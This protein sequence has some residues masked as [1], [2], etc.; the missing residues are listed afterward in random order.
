MKDENHIIHYIYE[1]SG[2]LP[3]FGDNCLDYSETYGN[4]ITLFFF[5]I[6]F[7][8]IFFSDENKGIISGLSFVVMSCNGGYFLNGIAVHQYWYEVSKK[9]S[10]KND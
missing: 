5:F 7:L 9:G 10:L 3:P 8:F 1:P 4:E 2:I 6:N